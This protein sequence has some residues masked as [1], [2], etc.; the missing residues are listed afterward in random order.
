MCQSDKTMGPSAME[1]KC[2][3]P[4]E[5]GC[6]PPFRRYYSSQEKRERLESY[7]DQ[8][9]KELDG[10]EERISGLET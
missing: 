4:C 8:L 2:C 9:K 3:G 1:G 6:C 10:V 7:R 5:C